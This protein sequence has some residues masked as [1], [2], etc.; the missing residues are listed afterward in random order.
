M[1]NKIETGVMLNNISSDVG[2]SVSMWT[3]LIIIKNVILAFINYVYG[4]R[5]I[6]SSADSVP[7][8]F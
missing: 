8:I 2:S 1:Y 3:L 6:S 5:F 7:S 4:L